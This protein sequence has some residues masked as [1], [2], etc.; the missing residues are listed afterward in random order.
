MNQI[1]DIPAPESTTGPTH[2][3]PEPPHVPAARQS[4]AP[5]GAAEVPYSPTL[6]APDPR[7]KSPLLAMILSALPGVGQVYIGYY[8]QGFM[9]AVIFAVLVATLATEQLEGFT[10]VVAIFMAF[11]WLYNVIDAGRRATL[12]NLALAG[13]EPVQLPDEFEMPGL[14]G[15]LTG[16]AL[17]L[18]VGFLLLLR[19]RFDVSMAWL[20]EWWPAGLMIVGAYLVIQAVRERSASKAS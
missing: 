18:F 13:G 20:Q 15:S 1:A 6:V 19:L 7:R 3:V 11:F 9:N 4:A 14:G 17:L 8:Q 16:G 10:P 12:Y 5:Q 2:P